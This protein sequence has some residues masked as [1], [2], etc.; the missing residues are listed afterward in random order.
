MTDQITLVVEPADRQHSQ[1]LLL[2]AELGAQDPPEILL[3]F[4]VPTYQRA[5]YLAAALDSI[6]AAFALC[7]SKIEI[8]VG[9]NASTDSTPDLMKQYVSSHSFIRFIRNPADIGA[10]RNI[11]NL[12]QH[13]RGEYIWLLADDDI[14]DLSASDIFV[15]LQRSPVFVVTNYSVWDIEMRVC[16][17]ANFYHEKN[18]RVFNTKYDLMKFFGPFTSFMSNLVI[19]RTAFRPDDHDEFIKFADCGM[20]ILFTTYRFYSEPAQV[21]FL[22]QVWVRQRGGNAHSSL[23]TRWEYY[24]TDGISRVFSELEKRG[25]SRSVARGARNRA[26]FQYHPEYI[27][28]RK[29]ERIKLR[30]YLSGVR[31]Q[32][33]DCWV[34]WTVLC[35]LALAPPGLFPAMKIIG[36]TVRRFLKK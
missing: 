23:F 31:R 28:S 25:Y 18:V 14:L 13:A 32:Y 6:L 19:K 34:F 27:A 4:C 36:K 20:S 12:C 15:A 16:K 11:W 29:A 8:V 10:E 35:P 17:D 30:G 3:S 5:E 7:H 2:A 21:V 9:D 22:P 33:Y 24:F 1:S 26:L